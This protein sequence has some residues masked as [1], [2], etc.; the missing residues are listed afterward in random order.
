MGCVSKTDKKTKVNPKMFMVYYL[1][2]SLHDQK[3]GLHT[4]FKRS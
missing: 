3:W 4:K 1:L 2:L